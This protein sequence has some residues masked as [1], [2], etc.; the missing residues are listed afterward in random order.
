MSEATT[1]LPSRVLTEIAQL[2]GSMEGSRERL[3]KSVEL[4]RRAMACDCGALLFREREGKA[5]ELIGMPELPPDYQRALADRLTS[6]FGIACG[7]TPPS[8][9]HMNDN[10]LAFPV[11]GED[12]M[13]G[14]L[15]VER[16][17]AAPPLEEE[18]LHL[19][20]VV[21]TQLGNYVVGLRAKARAAELD[22]FKTEM[23]SVVVHDLKNPL[24]VVMANADYLLSE[25]ADVSVDVRGAIDDIRS[26]SH[27]M[28]RMVANLLDLHRLESKTL[29]P[30]YEDLDLVHLLE[31]ITRERQLQ[32]TARQLTV[33]TR[34]DGMTAHAD[35]DL[36][37]RVIE[38]VLDNALRYTPKGGSIVIRAYT[39][40]GRLQLDIGNSG[41]AVPESFRHAIFEKYGHAATGSR[42]NLGLGLYF[43]KLA[44][45]AH[46]G[47]MWVDSLPDL[48]TV[49]RI[50]LP[51]ASA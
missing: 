21:G 24:S 17:R 4:L 36:L 49:F 27:R 33:T 9:T 45:T 48:P 22:D 30:A 35:S 7:T 41:P 6:L 42:L 37:S 39:D 25:L 46:G 34:V 16:K 50:T 10:H 40:D 38:N 43:C 31:K 3:Q 5:L 1:R 12:E 2:L 32:A 47:R 51:P 15:F 23:F 44:V 18:D 20:T 19:L 11:V 29:R 8:A 26:A 14:L 28:V 13:L